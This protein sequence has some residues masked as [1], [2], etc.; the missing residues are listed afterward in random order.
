[1]AKERPILFST[2]MVQAILA[3]KKTQTRRLV[4]DCP[5]LTDDMINQANVQMYLRKICPYGEKADK[6]WVRETWQTWALG[7]IYKASYGGDLPKDVSWKPSIHMPRKACRITLKIDDVRVE[8]LHDIS[9]DNARA[10]GIK[11]V[12]DF[13]WKDYRG[14][15]SGF[16]FDAKINSEYGKN[17]SGE[18]TSFASLW[19]KINGLDSWKAN[20]FVWVITFSN[21]GGEQ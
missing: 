19:A 11:M 2:E 7:W 8:R 6:L 14:K 21:E 9:D 4:K 16:D 13:N 18:V 12:D 20:P 3:G 10:E 1:M 15:Y 5:F 17:L